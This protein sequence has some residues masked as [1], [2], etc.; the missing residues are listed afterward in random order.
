MPVLSIHRYRSL[1]FLT[2]TTASRKVFGHAAR[3][4]KPNRLSVRQESA[5]LSE[6]SLVTSMGFV[7]PQQ[8]LR[9]T[10]SPVS[11]S[12]G[13]YKIGSVPS[14]LTSITRVGRFGIA[15]G[16]RSLMAHA[17]CFRTHRLYH[18]RAR[19]RL[20][21]DPVFPSAPSSLSSR[22][23]SSKS[24]LN[25]EN[26]SDCQSSHKCLRWTYWRAPVLVASRFHG[27]RKSHEC[28]HL[29]EHLSRDRNI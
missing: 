11:P 6:A 22:H 9:A 29:Q 15:L 28:I 2:T 4:G 21:T 5:C 24:W 18:A 7:S 13:S 20:R 8:W 10:Y 14:S 1:N 12:K 17:S 27:R 19:S 16:R 26:G 3:G 25:L 23:K